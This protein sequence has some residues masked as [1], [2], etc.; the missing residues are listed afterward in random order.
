M[1]EDTVGSYDIH[2]E[3]HGPHWV[4]WV[5]R[6]GSNKPD[7][8]VLLVAESQDKAE[9]RARAWAEKSVPAAT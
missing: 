8:S 4:A 9:E 2:S 7:Q 5:T 6:P 3:A 1:S